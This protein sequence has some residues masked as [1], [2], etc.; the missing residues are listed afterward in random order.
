MHAYEVGVKNEKNMHIFYKVI[1]SVLIWLQFGNYLDIFSIQICWY[2]CFCG[3]TY[4]SYLLNPAR[5]LN[6]KSISRIFITKKTFFKKCF[7]CFSLHYCEIQLYPIY[8]LSLV[9]F[10]IVNFFF[11]LNYCALKYG[12]LQDY[13]HICSTFYWQ[14]HFLIFFIYLSQII[15]HV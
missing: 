15:G 6:E 11:F 12:T 3:I 8:R 7:A 14:M 9:I 1:V 13:L 4:V 10:C 5:K 2:C